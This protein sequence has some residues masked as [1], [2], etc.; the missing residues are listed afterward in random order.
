MRSNYINTVNPSNLILAPW[1]GLW[2]YHELVWSGSVLARCVLF[3][4]LFDSWKYMIK[5]IWKMKALVPSWKLFLQ[6]MEAFITI[7]LLIIVFPIVFIF[8]LN[9]SLEGY[10]FWLVLYMPGESKQNVHVRYPTPAVRL[11]SFPEVARRLYRTKIIL[12][13]V[14]KQVV[15]SLNNGRWLFFP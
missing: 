1:Y 7:F 3:L 14:L 15:S 8:Y 9:L 11:T 10:C 13:K 4:E 2:S 5:S 6:I 12:F